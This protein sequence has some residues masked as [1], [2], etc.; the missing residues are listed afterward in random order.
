MVLDGEI[1]AV[2]VCFV[3]LVLMMFVLYLYLVEWILVVFLLA[4][5]V[6]VG[7]MIGSGLYLLPD[8]ALIVVWFCGVCSLLQRCTWFLVVLL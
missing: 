4:V 6:L 1:S 3:V 7:G 2:V 5:I 8:C